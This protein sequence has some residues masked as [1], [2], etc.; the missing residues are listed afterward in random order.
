L[1]D[2]AESPIRKAPVLCLAFNRPDLFRQVVAAIAEGGPRE[3]FVS[4]DGPRAGHS[5]DAE[6]CNRVRETAERID[7]AT[8]VNLKAEKHNL[9]LGPAVSSA[10]SW[11]LTKTSEVIVLEDDCLPDP[12][13]LDFCDELLVRYRDDERVMQISGTNWGAEPSTFL[14][15]SY[16]FTSFAP[17]WGWAT[18]RR[19]WNLYDYEL[20]SWPR[21]KASGLA[22]GIPVSRRVR[23]LLHRDWDR[24]WAGGGN[25]DYQWQYTV[26]RHNG[27]SAC[28]ER[29]L[30]KNIGF[31]EDATHLKGGDRIF[32]NLP[33]ER[34]SL[35]LRHP[36][37]VAR[38]PAVEAVFERIYWQKRG[39]PSELFGRVVR[40]P[41]LNRMLRGA[42]HNVLRVSGRS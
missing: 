16:A 42:W 22:D 30:V 7:W 31:R 25:W 24:V 41:R 1:T 8:G 3:L 23:K 6:L 20:E 2:S 29:N 35:P 12:S 10:I 5:G 28:P 14:G 37:E 32:S 19:A 36:P 40:N 13:F 4:I 9:G 17:I 38:N 34:L 39:W 15:H 11:V 33:L 26:L 27:L 18:W 21:M